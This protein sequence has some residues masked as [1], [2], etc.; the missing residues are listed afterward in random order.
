M[1]SL[2]K[3]KKKL[4]KIY[5]ELTDEEINEILEFLDM[6]AKITVKN[7]INSKLNEEK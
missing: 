6:L 2:E 5:P 4:I 3:Y 1:D 7:Y